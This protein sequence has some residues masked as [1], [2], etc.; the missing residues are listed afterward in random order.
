[1]AKMISSA[2]HPLV[3][4]FVKLRHNRSYREDKGSVLIEGE[5]IIKE[6]CTQHEAKVFLATHEELV[7]K[8]VLFQ[9]LIIINE[10][11][12]K[13]ISGLTFH[14]GIFAEI[15]MPESPTLKNINWLLVCDGISDPGNLGALLRSGLALG[16]DAAFILDNCCDPYNDK[17]LRSAKGATF[18][19]PLTFGSWNE[20]QE[21]AKTNKLKPLV[22]DMEGIPVSQIK[23]KE[24]F[25]LLL[26]N[27]SHGISESA[28]EF[29]TKVTIPMLGE[30][31]SLNVAVAGGILM[32]ALRQKL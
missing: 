8:G 28:K 6:V 23:E 25:L 17:A 9:D 32:F 22:A 2:Q 30:M 15:P 21:I 18:R 26:S 27:E 16:W 10:S 19:L 31:E 12:A 1:M 13:K 7:P 5:K 3:K 11:I 4:H 20:L 14:E 29:C 24:G